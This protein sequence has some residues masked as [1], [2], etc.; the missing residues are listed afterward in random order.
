MLMGILEKFPYRCIISS[1][2]TITYEYQLLF[3]YTLSRT[4]LA[5]FVEY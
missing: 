2:V 1:L 5:M 3:I 4:A